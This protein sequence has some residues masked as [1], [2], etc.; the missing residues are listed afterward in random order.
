MNWSSIIIFLLCITS[1]VNSFKLNP[2][3]IFDAIQE[4]NLNDIKHII[5]NGGDMN[6]KND[7]G[8]YPL[9][10]ACEKGNDEIVKLLIGNGKADVNA[11]NGNRFQSALIPAAGKGFFSTVELLFQAGAEP[12]QEA[13][14]L[15]VRK[16]HEDIVKMFDDRLDL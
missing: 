8:Y 16:G 15:A 11:K 3:A 9:W 14:G 13:Y 1:L 5:K 4:E 12:T 10:F 6:Q 7:K 2:H